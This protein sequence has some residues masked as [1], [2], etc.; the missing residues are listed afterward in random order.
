MPINQAMNTRVSSL[1]PMMA[2]GNQMSMQMPFGGVSGSPW[3]AN[4]QPQVSSPQML[5]P[6]QFVVP[7]VGTNY[8]VAHQQA[9]MFAKQAYQI[10][11]AQQAMAAAADEW[12]RNSVMGGSM[13]GD[14]SSNASVMMSPSPFNMRNGWS[15][16]SVIFPNATQSVYG[17]MGGLASSRSEYGGG[18]SVANM[19]GGKWNSARSMYGDNSGQ[20]NRSR[21]SGGGEGDRNLAAMNQGYYPPVPPIPH[22][23]SGG[24]SLS[25]I[26]GRGRASSGPAIPIRGGM[27]KAPG[28]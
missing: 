4:F 8:M 27:R 16:G 25:G 20:S 15:T 21:P 10:A 23:G 17:G 2:M 9:M 18:G 22:S 19:A 6:P 28:I 12:D 7:T 13:Y 14:P 26:R 24:S 5:V 1:H 3:A 11:V